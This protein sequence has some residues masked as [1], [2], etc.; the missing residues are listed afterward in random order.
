MFNL[1][2][3][4]IIIILIIALIFFGPKKLPE[5]GRSIGEGL[6]ELKRASNEFMHTIE[7]DDEPE[8]QKENVANAADSG[9]T[10]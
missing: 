7:A 9:R 1:G 6:R 5:I 10:K 8:P 4:E 3:Q 2:A